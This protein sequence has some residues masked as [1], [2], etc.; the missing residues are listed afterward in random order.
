MS[1]GLGFRFFLGILLGFGFRDLGLTPSPR[2]WLGVILL[3]GGGGK[4][5]GFIAFKG[6][7]WGLGV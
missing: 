7:F 6:V 3:R 5:L 2:D 4:G 1:L